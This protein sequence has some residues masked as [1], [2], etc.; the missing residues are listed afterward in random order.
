MAPLN[1]VVFSDTPEA[2]PE[3][4]GYRV[5]IFPEAGGDTPL[6]TKDYD[7]ADV[8]SNGPTELMIDLTAWANT[9]PVP[10]GTYK[11]RIKALGQEGQESP[12]G[13]PHAES[14]VMT[15]LDPPSAISAT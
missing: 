15:V 3:V 13:A 9:N 2:P 6:A 11:L 12:W 4:R 1:L 7:N 10:D 8:Q 5:G 14:F